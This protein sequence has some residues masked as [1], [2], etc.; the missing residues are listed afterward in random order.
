VY[1]CHTYI[2]ATGD[3]QVNSSCVVI[4]GAIIALGIIPF[5]VRND[6]RKEGHLSDTREFLDDVWYAH[7]QTGFA[8]ISQ[9]SDEWK[10]HLFKYSINQEL[11]RAQIPISREELYFCP[12]LFDG[13]ARRQG[14]VLPSRWL[15][16]D[17]DES[18][19]DELAIPPTACWETS[20]GRWQA[21]WALKRPL[22]PQ[23]HRKLNQ[24][25]TYFCNADIGGWGLTKVLRVPGSVSVKHGEPFHIE[26]PELTKVEYDPQELWEAVKHIQ[27]DRIVV[28]GKV[29][30]KST[31]Q[32]RRLM[33]KVPAKIRPLVRRRVVADRSKH[34][35]HVIAALQEAGF[36]AGDA[37]TVAMLSPVARDKY[38][39]R[40]KEQ[41]EL[42]AGKVYAKDIKRKPAKNHANGVASPFTMEAVNRFMAKDIPT[43]KWLI[44]GIWS[45]EA[46]GMIAGEHKAFKSLVALDLAVSVASG[47]NFLGHFPVPK[48]GHVAFIQE[49]N[50]AGFVKDRLEKILFSRGLG[51]GVTSFKENELSLRGP[52]DVPLSL[53]L[54]QKFHLTDDDHLDFLYGQVEKH[55]TKLVVLD[56]L[57]LMTPGVD[58]NSAHA[59]TPI[60]EALLRMKQELG[61]GVLL[62]HHYKKQN[63]D[64]P[65]FG[66]DDRI[67]GTGT[68]GRWYESLLLIERGDEPS[69]IRLVPKHRMESP[70][71]GLIV[72]FDMGPMG[73]PYYAPQVSVPQ[74][75]AAELFHRIRE[76]IAGEPGVTVAALAK[77]LEMRGE[78]LKRQ[79]E[80]MDDV[81][82][83]EMPGKQS[84]KLYVRKGGGKGR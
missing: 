32:A 55:N 26:V 52:S 84:P 31:K 70:T 1:V 8:C 74:D 5:R 79:L 37:A 80:R 11:D 40:L 60:L 3:P 73:D 6:S 51:P 67:S 24:K 68:F 69:Q 76:L 53:M 75:E 49:E 63:R 15:Y 66:E 62:I 42:A 22:A 83:K 17:L 9:K 48:V 58:E 14:S 41:L 38:G 50:P 20:P 16:A 10:D 4:P 29:D 34:L 54:N 2:V 65:F 19:P 81:R 46:H 12:N 23:V 35:Y 59:M 44:D 7:Q 21:L 33:R 36:E 13:G 47:T 28:A 82:V 56:P 27:T 39:P 72:D 30:V 78:R 64:Q 77:E 25:L 45:E 18:D 71:A 61:C 43:P 57:Y